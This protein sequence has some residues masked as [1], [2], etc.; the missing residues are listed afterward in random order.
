MIRVDGAGVVAPLVCVAILSACSAGDSAGQPDPAT[1]PASQAPAAT[2]SADAVGTGGQT[3]SVGSG[4]TATVSVREQLARLPAPSDAVLRTTSVTGTCTIRTD[5]TFASSSK[6]TVDLRTLTS[7]QSQR[8]RFI[9]MNPLET[10][11]YP[12]AEFVPTRATGLT[13]PLPTTGDGSFQ[14][15]GTMTIHGTS[16]P[17]TFDVVARST[18]TGFRATATANPTF[19]FEDFGMKPPSS[20]F[21]LSVVDEVKLQLEIA[22][23]P[24]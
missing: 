5:G 22:A 15:T 4:S 18:G 21:V 13:F 20:A 17:L 10:S 7:D 1:Q 2:T 8:D 14:L 24:Q 9:M 12:T 3:F 6:I 19:K 16:R 23:A 11:K